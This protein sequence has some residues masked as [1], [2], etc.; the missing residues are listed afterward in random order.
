MRKK[1]IRH[2]SIFEVGYQIEKTWMKINY[3]FTNNYKLFIMS[4]QCRSVEREQEMH[5]LE[6]LLYFAMY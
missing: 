6:I 1:K 2:Y 5:P 3:L 4:A